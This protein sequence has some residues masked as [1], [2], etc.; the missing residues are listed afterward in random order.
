[1]NYLGAFLRWKIKLYKYLDSFQLCLFLHSSKGK[2]SDSVAQLVEQY[3]F[4]V[5]A[6][7]SSP[8]GIT[9]LQRKLELFLCEA[10]KQACLIERMSMKKANATRSDAFGGFGL[11]QC[12][13]KSD[14]QS[15]DDIPSFKIFG[16]TLLKHLARFCSLL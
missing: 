4:N 16:Q 2:R 15:E 8:S 5:W 9:K 11:D 12:G 6:L 10:A 1:M 14:E 7:G 3:T 13:G